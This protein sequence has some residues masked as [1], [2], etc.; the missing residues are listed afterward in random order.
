M[1]PSKQAIAWPA[2]PPP[3]IT[4]RR[5][6]LPTSS[7][8]CQPWASSSLVVHPAPSWAG[9]AG[10][11]SASCSDESENILLMRPN[12]LHSE[13]DC[14]KTLRLNCKVCLVHQ[15]FSKFAK[16][17]SLF[18]LFLAFCNSDSHVRELYCNYGVESSCEF[19][20]S[21]STSTSRQV[22]SNFQ[23]RLQPRPS[24]NFKF[25]ISFQ[26]QPVCVCSLL[27]ALFGFVSFPHFKFKKLKL[28]ITT[29]QSNLAVS[30]KPLFSSLISWWSPNYLTIMQ[31]CS[32]LSTPTVPYASING[33]ARAQTNESS[34]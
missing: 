27:L 22:L 3:T 24:S 25:S 4:N 20:F 23:V 29:V 11:M 14:S 30:F 28:R 32:R 12:I 1:L 13:S 6:H 16:V 34:R 17:E 15:L 10:W 19:V 5:A 2:I 21:T 8:S 9:L 18:W 7:A 33:T 26:R 31:V